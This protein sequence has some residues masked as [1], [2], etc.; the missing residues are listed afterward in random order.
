MYAHPRRLALIDMGTNTFHLLIVEMT[1]T[2]GDKPVVLLR[3]KAGVR[4]GEGGISRGEIA[5]EACARALHTLAG[6]VQINLTQLTDSLF[7]G[8]NGLGQVV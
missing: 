7:T 3:T 1:V 5:P 6:I 2:P 8:K 4:L